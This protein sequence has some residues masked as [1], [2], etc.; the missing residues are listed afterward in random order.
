MVAVTEGGAIYEYDLDGTLLFVFGGPDRGDQRLGLLSYPTAIE[1]VGD[2]L[3][4]LDRDKNAIIVYRVTDFARRLHDGVRLYMNGFYSEARPYFED[5]LTFNGLV[6]MAYQALADADYSEGHYPTALEYYRYAEDREGY[7]NAFWELRNSVLQRYLGSGLLLLVGAWVV[8]SGF[9]WLERRNHWLEPLRRLFSA[10]GRIRLID[11]FV[12]MFRFIRQPADSFYYIKQRQRGSLLFAFLLYGWVVVSHVLSLYVTGFVFNPYSASWQI[13][14]ET[15][16]MYVL[17][18]I[19]LWNVANYLVATISDGE[20][21]LRHVIIGTA[22]SL[23]PYALLA[24]PIALLSNLLTMNEVFLYTFATQLMLFW[25]GL[26]LVIMVREVHNYSVSETVRN[27][28][29]TLFTM[30]IFLLTGYVL[31][32]LFNQLYE[33]VLAIIQEVSLRG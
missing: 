28:L 17:G 22:Y 2:D 13:Y 25:C 27:L 1:R 12:F 9:S 33:F 18:A 15:E 6:L 16:I 24:L 32:V 21:S 14:V 11:D 3:L 10:V 29:I 19:A 23:F 30:A 26:M 7:S 20:G 4:V 31:Y 8:V 5:V